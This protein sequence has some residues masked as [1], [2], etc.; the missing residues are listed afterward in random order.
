MAARET[1]GRDVLKG[2]LTGQRRGVAIG[3]VLA[4]G[5]Q[6]G[7]ALVPVL[8]GMVID[9]AVA[10]DDAGALVRWLLVLVAVY[11]VLALSFRLGVKAA[12]RAAELAAHRV[13]LD[14]V[15]R[16][17]DPR[18]GAE[19]GR[20]P[21]A[22]ANIA[23]DDAK[24]VG[25]IVMVVTVG[26]SGLAGAAVSAVA[27]LLISVPLGLLVLVGTPV[28]LWLG[29][30]LSKPLEHRSAAEQERAATASGVAAD[31]VAGLRVLK[32]IGARDAAVER[33]RAT[34][35][36]S[37]AATLRAARAEG[38]QNGV[39]L[40]LTGGFIALVALVG[41]RL[42][43]SGDITL[44]QLVAAVGLAQFLLTPLQVFAYV[45][46]EFA[47]A[48]AS[49]ARVAEVLAAAPAVVP[50]DRRLA[51]PVRGELRLRG[52]GLGALAEVDMAVAAG[53]LVGVATTEPAAAEALLRCLGRIEDPET[54]VVELD[55]VPL[56]GLDPAELRT[57]VLVAAHDADLFAGTVGENVTAA[58]PG[59]A[60]ADGAG[61]GGPGAG[62]DRSGPEPPGRDPGPA[63]AAAAAD[64]VAR[65]LPRGARTEVGEAGR[66]LSGGQRQRVALARALH[67]GRP[68]L[69]VHDPTTAV[70]VVTE[71]RIARGLRD[72]RAGMTT[73]LVTNS[74]AL[75]AVADRVVFVDAGR[76]AAQGPHADLVR[77]EA[78]YR[79]AVL[80]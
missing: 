35:R 80:A 72:H 21:G 3:S 61:A 15:G 41:G 77:D 62:A 26:V 50:G 8:I 49:A 18:G 65:T 55:G 11:V 34:S 24:R 74:P 37:L 70:D 66:A 57:A 60:G 76:V 4:V 73:L 39:V 71:A 29:H 54:G 22:V 6:L 44:G 2:A 36:D 25:Y 63:M 58:D 47:Q 17:L 46:A 5:H 16:V 79:T 20:L 12:E 45:N 23:T 64:E 42:A 31:L 69:V 30:L 27:L 33:Y 48:R 53:E 1:S 40:A 28:L 38:W 75:L 59:H 43:L 9:D 51:E 52:V 10:G 67:A 19:R 13:R 32:G 78:A 56:T 68:V 7:E 14:L